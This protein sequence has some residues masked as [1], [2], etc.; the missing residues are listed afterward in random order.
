VFKRAHAA[1]PRGVYTPAISSGVV[2]VPPS[3]APLTL[4]GSS[5]AVRDLRDEADYAA[6]SD[7]A[8]LLAGERGVGKKFLARLVHQH[9]GR[10]GAPFVAVGCAGIPEAVLEDMLFGRSNGGHGVPAALGEADGGVVFL[11]AIGELTLRLQARLMRFL[12]TGEV[13]AAGA[14]AR[15]VDVRILSST[16]VPLAGALEAG[17]FRDDL[18][19]RLNLMYL[20][21]PAL[22]DRRGDVDP[23]LEH[24]TSHHAERRGVE[25]PPLTG[26]WRTAFDAYAWPENVRELEAAADRLVGDGRR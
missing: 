23:L 2:D 14:P 8:V 21:I 22:R 5:P 18:Y 7:A 24:F 11:D 6:R 15:R 12:D 4:I 25:P 9:S 17:A 3:P 20:E 19:Y 13:Q 1:G 26:P 10:C 16:R